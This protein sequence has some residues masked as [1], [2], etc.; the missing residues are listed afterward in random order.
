MRIDV[1]GRDV[2]MTDALREHAESKAGKLLRHFDRTQLITVTASKHDHHG[3]YHVEIVVDVEHHEAFIAHATG[4]DL[5][6]VIE[7]AVAK[8]ARQLTDHKERVHAHR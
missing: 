4:T 6:G 2:E 5:Y 1:V 7:G 8:S 3:N